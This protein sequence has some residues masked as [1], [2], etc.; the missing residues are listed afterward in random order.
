MA[1]VG[2]PPLRVKARDAKGLSEFLKL[3]KHRIFAS[4]KDIRS[5]G[6]TVVINGVSEPPRF[7][8]LS[9]IT[10]HLIQL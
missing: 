9:H 1:R 8:F 3:E 4:S 2:A 7:R 5:H 6:S 10:P